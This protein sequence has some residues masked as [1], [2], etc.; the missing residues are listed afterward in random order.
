MDRFFLVA[1]AFNAAFTKAMW[2]ALD[3][4][5]GFPDADDA[6]DFSLDFL[7]DDEA[8]GDVL[9][10]PDV[11]VGLDDADELDEADDGRIP[12]TAADP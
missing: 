10:V 2:A 11:E 4:A 8:L 7:E 9:D 5:G 3:V 6:E 1:M 12:S